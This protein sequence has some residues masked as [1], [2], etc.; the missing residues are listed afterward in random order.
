MAFKSDFGVLEKAEKTAFRSLPLR[1]QSQILAVEVAGLS[2]FQDQLLTLKAVL[3]CD[4][5]GQ[6]SALGL[7]PLY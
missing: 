3:N 1:A 2:S 4:F 6:D 5:G 7:S